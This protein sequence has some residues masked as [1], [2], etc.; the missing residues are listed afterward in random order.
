MRQ[1]L[2]ALPHAQ[3]RWLL[4]VA[5]LTGAGLIAS[6]FLLPLFTQLFTDHYLAA[7]RRAGWLGALLAGMAAAALLRAAL[8]WLQRRL[9][10]RI[11]LAAARALNSATFAAMLHAGPQTLAQLALGS[12]GYLLRRQ[13]RARLT[14]PFHH[15]SR[16]AHVRDRESSGALAGPASRR[17]R[18]HACNVFRLGDGKSFPDRRGAFRP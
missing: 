6:G 7:D 17:A 10:L 2:L 1:L 11:Q 8:T 16:C 5:A 4:L 9:L 18:A 13:Q 14:H 3:S 12:S 15:R